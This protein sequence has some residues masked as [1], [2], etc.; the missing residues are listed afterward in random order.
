MPEA[1]TGAMPGAMTG[2][3]P[4]AMIDAVPEAM[5]G[6]S[7]DVVA[8]AM[9]GTASGPSPRKADVDPADWNDWRWQAR[10]M[11]TSAEGFAR[12]LALSDDEHAGLAASP[13]L[14]RVGAT[15]YYASLMDPAHPSCPIR[16]QSIPS[17]R[18]LDLAP[19]ELR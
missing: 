3:M 11:I 7:A 16:K 19:E 17:L 5:T 2:A 9:A 6:A 12:L 13:G 8:G 15:P 18:E 4:G 1:M 14:F 10:N